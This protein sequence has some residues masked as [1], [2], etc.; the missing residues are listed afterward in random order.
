MNEFDQLWRR[1]LTGELSWLNASGEPAVLPVTPLTSGPDGG[2]CVALPY[3]SAGEVAG[4]R[5]ATEVAFSVTDSRSLQ[6][7]RAGRAALGDVEIIDDTEGELFTV[8]LL[9][10][11]LVKYPPTRTLADS[12]LLCRENWWWLPRIIVRLERVRTELE[13]PARTN[14]VTQA[15]LVRDDGTGLTLDTVTVEH[16]RAPV[17]LSQLGGRPLRGD[18]APSVACGYDYSMPDLERWERWSLR[19]ALRGDE[20]TVTRRSGNPD[21]DLAPLSLLPRI[22]RQRAL[23]RD[24]RRELAAI[25]RARRA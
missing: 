25:E 20:L 16:E 12:P 3:S 24:C 21:A 13:L 15:V 8:E 9:R 23:S 1:A 17:R 18:G 6:R 19:G 22:R 14:P 10:Q 5:S 11:E 4:L 2:A 7:A